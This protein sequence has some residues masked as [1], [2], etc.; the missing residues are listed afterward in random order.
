ASPVS[1]PVNLYSLNNPS[2]GVLVV[3]GVTHDFGS[4]GGDGIGVGFGYYAK[5]S[6]AIRQAAEVDG[7]W[8]TATDASRKG[9][10]VLSAL[11]S[12]GTRE[13]LRVEASGSAAMIGFLGAAAVVRQNITGVRTGTLAQLQTVVANL[14]TGLANLGL[15]TD[16]TT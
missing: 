3:A 9:R 6:T 1:I 10:L 8:A 13:G 7:V 2:N 5:T 16:S 15:I 12:S 14:L 4:T 11:D